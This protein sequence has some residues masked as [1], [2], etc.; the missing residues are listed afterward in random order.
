MEPENNIE[1]ILEGFRMSGTKMKLMVVGNTG[2]NF[3][4]KMINKFANVS[5]IIFIGALYDMDKLNALRYYCYLYFH[6]HSV[7]GT[8][9]S[10]LEA[11]ASEALICAHDNLFNRSVLGPDSFYFSNALQ[12]RLAIENAMTDHE[13]MLWKQNNKVKIINEHSWDCIISSYENLFSD[14]LISIV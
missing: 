9:P 12:I 13:K 10:L 3:A 14:K 1:S 6:G 7:G 8:N 11:M 4:N 5:N 2:N